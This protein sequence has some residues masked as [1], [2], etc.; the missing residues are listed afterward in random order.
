MDA[1]TNGGILLYTMTR[2]PVVS[3]SLLVL[4]LPVIT[5]TVKGTAA[6]AIHA[7]PPATPKRKSSLTFTG[8][9]DTV[10]EPLPPETTLEEL[11]AFLLRRES[12]NVLAAGGGPA[13]EVHNIDM[14]PA[15]ESLWN[16]ACDHWYGKDQLPS[17]GDTLLSCNTYSHFPGLEV[18]TT[19][20][21]GVKMLNHPTQP[22]TGRNNNGLPGYF[23]LVIGQKQSAKGLAPVVWA[24]KQLMGIKKNEGIKTIISNISSNNG[25]SSISSLVPMGPAKSIV[26]VE[27]RK[28]DGR[29]CFQLNTDIQVK[30]EF[31]EILLKILPTSRA[32]AEAQGSASIT[33]TVAKAGRLGIDAAFQEFIDFQQEERRKH[34][35][36]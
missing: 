26:T 28:N 8:N 21:T 36:P 34:T 11:T 10:S 2:L 32:K 30:I 17:K 35:E 22:S 7:N 19:V 15:W 16:K 29:W 20:I 5:Q 14:S 1:V 13:A 12:R 4:L 18:C 24:F 27:Q 31:P 6:A 33:K 3:V 25:A 23:F 9:V